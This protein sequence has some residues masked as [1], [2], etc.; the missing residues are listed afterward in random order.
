M[1]DNQILIVIFISY[2]N[3]VLLSKKGKKNKRMCYKLKKYLFV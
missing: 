2:V 3:I 1:Y